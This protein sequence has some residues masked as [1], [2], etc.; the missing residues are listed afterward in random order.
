VLKKHESKYLDAQGRQAINFQLTVLLFL[1]IC[2]LLSLI[3][4]PLIAIA[5]V[6]GIGGLLFAAMAAI[7]VYREGNFEYPFYFKII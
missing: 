6:I 4:K 5:F 3:I 2:F 1:F 7:M